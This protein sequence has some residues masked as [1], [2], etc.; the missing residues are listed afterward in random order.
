MNFPGDLD[1]YHSALYEKSGNFTIKWVTGIGGLYKSSH[2]KYNNTLYF[3]KRPV[4][5]ALNCRPLIESATAI[6]TVDHLRAQVQHYQILEGA[7][8]EDV[9][10][11]DSFELRN[12]ALDDSSGRKCKIGCWG[13]VTIR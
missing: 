3:S 11:S 1:V 2:Y 5:Q 7:Q 6:V 4:I 8:P 10:W 12:Q 9:A 13:N